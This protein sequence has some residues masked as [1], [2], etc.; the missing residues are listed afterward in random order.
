MPRTTLEE[1]PITASLI[2]RKGELVMWFGSDRRIVMYPCD[3]DTLLN[4]VCI[5]PESESQGSGSG[6]LTLVYLPLRK[7]TS[8]QNGANRLHSNSC[9]KCIRALIQL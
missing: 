8:N 4:F 2:E 6:K 7:L 3:N 9:S 5:H 1:D